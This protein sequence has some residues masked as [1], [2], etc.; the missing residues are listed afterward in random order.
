[1]PN[2]PQKS[3]H[4]PAPGKRE[5]PK[6]KQESMTKPV[7]LYVDDEEIN[8][9]NFVLFFQNDFQILT[10]LNGREALPIFA[11]RSDLAVVITDQ[12]MPE[13]SGVKFL[14]EA[15]RINPDPIRILLTAYSDVHDI[16]EAINLGHIHQYVQKPWKF[17]ELHL[18][19]RSA[20]DKSRITQENKHLL[21][22]LDQKNRQLTAANLQLEADLK[23]QHE[24]ESQRRDAEI[25]MLSQAKLASLGE[26]ATGIAHE[27]NQP[28]TY[29][30]I[31][32]QSTA[33]DI[34]NKCLD[35]KE[36]RCDIDESIRQ[37][38]RI[39]NIINHLRTF[40]RADSGDSDAVSLP[41]IL[42]GTLVLYSENLRL[43]NIQLS[44][45]THKDLPLVYGNIN[46][47]E[48]VF[49][50]LLQNAID[51][52]T[53]SD[54]PTITINFRFNNGMVET[55]LIDNGS[56]INNEIL[57]KIFEPFFTTKPTGK[58]TGLGLSIVYGIIAD[59][60]GAIECHSQPGQGCRFTFT[61]PVL[62]E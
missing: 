37:I 52:L 16:T 55:S 13:M 38:R 29:I 28:L 31:I 22:L 60:N 51:A 41:R 39:T 17:D 3:L 40:G 50:N 34:D 56:G 62:T 46:Q 20:V 12:R 36:L 58:G 61:L 26:I 30:Q 5:T 45:N 4:G 32:L 21:T 42:E 14:S 6:N 18:I 49:N 11:D 1:M 7:I 25:K 59:H 8:L 24:L 23:L 15:Y 33:K 19:L 2:L 53:D 57:T 43:R 10:A 48:Q 9:S 54:D 47:L 27:I 44:I 35:L